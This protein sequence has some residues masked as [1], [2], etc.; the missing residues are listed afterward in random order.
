M[1]VVKYNQIKAAVLSKDEKL[2]SVADSLD[3]LADA[4][5]NDCVGL[6]VPN[7]AEVLHLQNENRHY[8]RLQPLSKQKP[9][10]FYI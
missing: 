3:R 7:A 4:S 6:V 2:T 1:D 8:W 9:E 10:R 5:Y